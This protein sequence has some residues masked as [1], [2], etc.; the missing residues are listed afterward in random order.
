MAVMTFD[1]T[2]GLKVGDAVHLEV[3][4]RELTP[5]D[6]F[7]AQMASEHVTI[8][9]NRPYAY[10]SN[11]QFGMELLCRQ[12]EFIGSVNGPFTAKEIL[13]LD[14]T[15]FELL[16]AKAEELDKMMIPQEILDGISQRGEH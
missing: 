13:K 8:I 1:L 7:D 12:V 11:A 14:S 4:L 6:V 9:D 2:H 15:D 16:Q 3:G 5:K 10:I